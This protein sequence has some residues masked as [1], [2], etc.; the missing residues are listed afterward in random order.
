M[1]LGHFL[2]LLPKVRWCYPFSNHGRKRALFQLQVEILA[3]RDK[4]VF[5][6]RSS[7]ADHEIQ[8]G[9]ISLDLFASL[10]YQS[11]NS[12]ASSCMSRA[13]QQIGSFRFARTT[14]R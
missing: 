12:L 8:N 4:I 2:Y 9:L 6:S 13:L 7:S 11:T 10:C 1:V 14:G 3:G 5:E